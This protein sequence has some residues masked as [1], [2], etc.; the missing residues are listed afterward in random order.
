MSEVIKKYKLSDSRELRIILDDCLESP[1]KWDNLSTMVCFHKRYKLGDAHNY[2]RDDFS[3]WNELRKAIEKDHD[4][5]IIKPLYLYDHSGITISTNLEYPYDD[6]WDSGQIGWVFVTKDDIR[7]DFA[8]KK[9]TE[10]L[11]Q[12]VEDILLS[13]V[14]IYDQFLCG[15]VYAYEVIQHK[16]CETCGHVET[17]YLD[18]CGGFYGNDIITN[19]MLEHL[20]DDIVQEVKVIIVEE[21]I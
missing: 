21:R 18:S 15:E 9:V 4:I 12:K 11:I 13:E 14:Q 17:K 2:K 3:K 20:S 8:V 6:R 7:K 19:G 16:V 5:A 10:Q 1:R